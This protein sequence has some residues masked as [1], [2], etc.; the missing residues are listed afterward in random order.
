MAWFQRSDLPSLTSADSS[1]DPSPTS[2]SSSVPPTDNYR[3]QVNQFLATAVHLFQVRNEGRCLVIREKVW[4]Y[5]SYKLKIIKVSSRNLKISR[6]NYKTCF[7]FIIPHLIILL[8]RIRLS[9]KSLL[10]VRKR[11]FIIGEM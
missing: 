8:I 4:D 5:M 9:R 7:A 3:T 2:H 11:F 10:K 1:P 6:K